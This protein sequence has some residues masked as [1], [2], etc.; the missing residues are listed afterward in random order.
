[1]NANKLQQELSD[2]YLGIK[3]G[4]IKPIE[5]CEMNNAAGKM[6]KLAKLQLEYARIEKNAEG[7][8]KIR[9]DFLESDSFEPQ[10]AA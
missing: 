5:A 4:A 7:M 8:A 3:S 10:P 9:I 2:L 6:I 1:M